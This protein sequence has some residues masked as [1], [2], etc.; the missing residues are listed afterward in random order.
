M[1]LLGCCNLNKDASCSCHGRSEAFLGHCT[2]GYSMSRLTI[3]IYLCRPKLTILS[4]SLELVIPAVPFG[5]SNLSYSKT[6]EKHRVMGGAFCK[7][8]TGFCV[9]DPNYRSLS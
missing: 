4:P 9:K 5:R 1:L 6:L 2:P 3:I 8:F 7:G